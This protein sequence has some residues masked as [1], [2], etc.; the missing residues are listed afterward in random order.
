M[1]WPLRNI[2]LSLILSLRLNLFVKGQ[3]FIFQGLTLGTPAANGE[4]RGHHAMLAKIKKKAYGSSFPEHL[5]LIINDQDAE[6]DQHKAE[7]YHNNSD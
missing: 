7:E 2:F 1:S 4:P 6:D 3:K 5:S